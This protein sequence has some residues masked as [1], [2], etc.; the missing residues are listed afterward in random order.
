APMR[1]GNIWRWYTT[2]GAAATT[3]DL[4]LLSLC[5]AWML[6]A[7][8]LTIVAMCLFLSAATIRGLVSVRSGRPPAEATAR[9]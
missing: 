2:R 3:H 5:P 1:A 6:Y 7:G 4:S 9:V 8:L